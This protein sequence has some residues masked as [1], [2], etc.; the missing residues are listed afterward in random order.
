MEPEEKTNGTE[1][2]SGNKKNKPSLSYIFGGKVLTEDFF[3]KQSKLLF[4]IFCLIIL[5]ISNRYNCAKKLT[6]MDNL[7]RELIGL[8]NENVILTTKLTTIK[9]KAHIEELLQAKGIELT[10]DSTAVY[11]IKD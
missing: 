8:R 11:M 7:K 10:K 3:I 2:K 9:R 4:L 1:K 6:E 5:F